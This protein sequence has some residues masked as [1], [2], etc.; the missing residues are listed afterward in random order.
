MSAKSLNESPPPPSLKGSEKS[1][2]EEF[3]TYDLENEDERM[4]GGGGGKEKGR[5][6]TEQIK[7]A[8]HNQD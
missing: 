6:A 5:E 8:K 3:T 7:K 4:R 2:S 1:L